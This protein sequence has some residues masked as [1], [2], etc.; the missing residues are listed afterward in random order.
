MNLLF[1]STYLPDGNRVG[2]RVAEWPISGEITQVFGQMSVT[3]SRHGGMDIAPSTYRPIVY[4]PAPALVTFAMRES[5]GYDFGNWITLNHEGTPLYSA[6]AHL[7]E[8]FVLEGAR[9]LEGDPIGRVG[10]TGKSFGDHLHWAVSTNP[11]FALDFSQLSD[12][13]HYLEDE[14]D[15]TP[16]DRK[17]LDLAR[18]VLYRRGIQ[19]Y[20]RPSTADLF[21]EGTP[22]IAEDAQSGPT[23]VLTNDNAEA[24]VERRGFAF[25]LSLLGHMLHHP[26]ANAL[27]VELDELASPP[28]LPAGAILHLSGLVELGPGSGGLGAVEG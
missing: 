21:P 28:P 4:A 11:W 25:G 13:A 20:C 26:P 7:S 23:Y 6:Y 3:G 22:V 12:P 1:P 5:D 10:N 19:A 15:M 18:N 2:G 14:D 27:G 8:V 16:E 24:Y 9:I 17:A